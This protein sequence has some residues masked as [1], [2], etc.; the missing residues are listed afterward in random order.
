MKKAI[1]ILAIVPLLA[2]SLAA[3]N[4]CDD[5]YVKAMTAQS[6]GERAQLLKDFLTKC[7][8]K[9]SQYENFANANLAL[10][11]YPG[12]TAADVTSY[13][14]KAL[15]LGGLDDLS[16]CQLL[17]VLSSL[18]SKSGQNLEKA[19]SYATQVTEVARAAKG[20]EAEGATT[21]AAQWNQ[22]IGAGFF[23][24]GQ[25][26]EKGNDAKGAV[27]AYANSYAIL[28]NPQILASIKK[29]GKTLYDAKNYAA[30][31]AAFKAAYDATKDPE[32]GTIYAQS[33]YRSDKEAEAL[34]LFKELYAKKKSG[35]L[36][37]NIG[38]I[39]AKQAKTNP[40]MSTEAIRYLLEASFTY[41]A[42]AQQARGIAENLFFLSNKSLKYNE[43]VAMILE[44]NKKVEDLTKSYNAKFGGKDAEDLTSAEKAEMESILAEI[45]A[46]KKDIEKLQA[47]QATAVA[48]FNKML[49]DTRQRLGVK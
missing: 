39:V 2:G 47:S 7:S 22:M 49:E 16:K 9:G 31:E 36:A 46:E 33:L 10:Q 25:A 43:T 18:Y 32:I 14:E 38:I 23:A 5:A 19:K 8:G 28:K 13:G 44:R 20:K 12:K 6:P 30:A 42:Q 34:V 15:A 37:Y 1:L 17:I 45:E 21:T 11:E 24:L 35:E 3:Q 41:P 4:E 48:Q 26:R 29:L 27:D 40:A